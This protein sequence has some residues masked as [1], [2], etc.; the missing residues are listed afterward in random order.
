MHILQ[1]RHSILTQ[2]QVKKLLSDLNINPS[3]L[4][5]ISRK[6]PALPEGIDVGKIVKI[7]RKAGDKKTIFYR[8]VI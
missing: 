8:I 4:P 7:E 1:P 5:K 3:Q 6:D 2:E